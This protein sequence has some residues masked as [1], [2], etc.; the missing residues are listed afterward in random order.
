M[1]VQEKATFVQAYGKP[2]SLYAPVMCLP[3][4]IQLLL[5]LTA[6]AV[7]F[8]HVPPAAAQH[9]QQAP[10]WW[11]QQQQQQLESDGAEAALVT[12]Q[13]SEAEAA[14]GDYDERHSA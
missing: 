1:G 3:A 5:L 14:A 13:L 9:P 11:Q 4:V 12:A 10:Q 2:A 8:H 6:M 7:L